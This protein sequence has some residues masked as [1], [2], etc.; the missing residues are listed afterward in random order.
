MYK[1]LYIEN[2]F[3]AG[4]ALGSLS[5]LLSSQ[6]AGTIEVK[7]IEGDKVEVEVMCYNPLVMSFIEDHLAPYV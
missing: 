6:L 5:S 2:T 1:T 3:T 7:S 4:K